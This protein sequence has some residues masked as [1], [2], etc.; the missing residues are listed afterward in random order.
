MPDPDDPF[1][2]H[3]ELRDRITDADSSFFRTFDVEDLLRTYPDLEEF[4]DWVFTDTQREAIRA[5][6]LA[7][8]AGDLWVFAY[9]SLMWDPAL[10][11]AEVRHAHV[12]GHA[13]QFIL[14][15]D[16]G[17][18][19]TKEAPG[20]MAGLDTGDGCDGLAFRIPAAEVDTETEIL[21]R[22]EL[23]GPGYIPAF[24]SA[25]IG[26]TEEP[27]LTFLAD[28]ASPDIRAGI[29]RE[30]QVRYIATGAGLLGTSRDYLANIVGHFALLGI[31]DAH[32]EDLLRDVDA[33]LAANSEQEAAR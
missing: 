26:E 17:G 25:R 32:C 8:H 21:F 33:V 7:D 29:S 5:A 15:D 13:R 3:P 11:F 24:V 28:H 9:G 16:K 31:E 2:H 18:R 14:F 19:G 22:R 23:V 12:A 27:A 10:R 6:A 1:V 4:R 20:L 30:D